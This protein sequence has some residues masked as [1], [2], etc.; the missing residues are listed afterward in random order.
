MIHGGTVVLS[1]DGEVVAMQTDCTVKASVSPVES[2]PLPG[3]PDDDGWAHYEVGAVAWSV[4]NSSFLVPADKLVALGTGGARVSV[5][6]DAGGYT[7]AG[8]G[9]VEK[10]SVKSQNKSF[11]KVAI[12][13]RGEGLAACTAQNS[14]E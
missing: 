11:C 9:V 3:S 4:E 8:S 2:V 1:I 12:E 6:I 5:S 7:L 14:E 10:V 13:I